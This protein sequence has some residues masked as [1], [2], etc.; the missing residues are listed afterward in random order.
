L[1][2]AGFGPGFEEGILQRKRNRFIVFAKV[3]E[4]KVFFSFSKKCKKEK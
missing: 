3:Q 4:G 1:L 2:I